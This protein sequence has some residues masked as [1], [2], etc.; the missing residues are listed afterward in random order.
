M[1]FIMYGQMYVSLLFLSPMEILLSKMYYVFKKQI[2]K[3]N[4]GRL[5]SPN[6]VHVFLGNPKLRCDF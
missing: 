1:G 6:T 4:I 3:L 2:K 5:A